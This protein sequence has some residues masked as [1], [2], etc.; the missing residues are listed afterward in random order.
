M[1]LIVLVHPK[2]LP[3]ANQPGTVLITGGLGGIGLAMTSWMI[4]ERSVKSVVLLG[5]QAEDDIDKESSRW[6]AWTEVQHIAQLYGASVEIVKADVI[7]FD[8]VRHAIENTNKVTRPLYG[9]IHGALVLHDSLVTKMTPEILRSAMQ[10]RIRGAWNLHRAT[11][12]LNLNFFIMLSSARNH[13]SDIG[14]ANY[15]ASNQF[16][17]I[18]AHWR[19][20]VLGL[21]TLS[22]SL[23]PTAGTGYFNEGTASLSEFY[24]HRGIYILPTKIVFELIEHFHNFQYTT[25]LTTPIIY[26][27]DWILL[28]KMPEFT[29]GRFQYIVKRQKKK[30]QD[31]LEEGHEAFSSTVT[32]KNNVKES[33]VS[34][35]ETAIL[36][37][38]TTVGK[39]FGSTDVDRIDIHKS[40]TEQ[41]MD[42]LMAVSL[43][44]W[45]AKHL[46]IM[47]PMI[48]IVQGI[49]IMDIVGYI[50]NKLATPEFHTASS[51]KKDTSGRLDTSF[52][53]GDLS[54]ESNIGTKLDD[55]V[56]DY[57]GVSLIT[58]LSTCPIHTFKQHFPVLFCLPDMNMNHPT[59]IFSVLAAYVKQFSEL[60]VFRHLDPNLMREYIVQ[61][62]RVQPR[63]PYHIL[64]Y[65]S[66]IDIALD[67]L[68]T[69]KHHRNATVKLLVLLHPI[70]TQA[71]YDRFLS[72]APFNTNVVV[73]QH[74][75]SKNEWIKSTVFPYLQVRKLATSELNATL[76]DVEIQEIAHQIGI[77]I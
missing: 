58:S 46:N 8:Q 33:S 3:P 48:K 52:G 67:I 4:Q 57:N 19:R 76:S 47:I 31:S 34:T 43:H 15:N 12:S 72:M 59:E 25:S 71:I 62:R 56:N 32:D 63:G 23:P 30:M 9:I 68:E 18:F 53:E 10:A 24:R 29:V 50:Q 66:S 44:N 51:E 26:C 45:L 14:G 2:F 54:F 40:L 16:Y 21:P 49:S 13:H 35:I 60:C 61:M 65:G 41:G 11:A 64:A 74:K 20:H 1:P 5:R 75:Y 39:L 42:S 6:Q 37:I 28:E 27:A 17:D 55:Q 22:V 36:N 7:N 77:D 73:L 70:S 69:L 38:R